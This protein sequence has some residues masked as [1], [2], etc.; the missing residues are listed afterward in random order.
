MTTTTFYCPTCH[1]AMT[2]AIT[3]SCGRPPV[4]H[5]SFFRM[6]SG[7]RIKHCPGCQR[8][9]SRATPAQFEDQLGKNW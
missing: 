3:L 8:D 6:G 4:R 7:E 1:T 5:I 9:F 2:A